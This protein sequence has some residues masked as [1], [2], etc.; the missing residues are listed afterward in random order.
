MSEPVVAG[1]DA[2]R[3]MLADLGPLL[4]SLHDRQ[5]ANPE[6]LKACCAAAYGLDLITTFLGEW[7]HPGGVDLT[8][9]LADALDLRPGQHVLDVA[10]GIGSTALL[11]AQERAVKV[12]G[13][14]LGAAQ[15]AKA[16][17]RAK[18]LGLERVICFE[19]GDAERLPIDDAC[20]DAV[21]CECAFCTFPNK[22]T[23]AAQ[24]ARVLRPGGKA[25]IADVW[26]EPDRLEPEL[27]GVAGHI[28]CLADAKPIPVIH[29]LLASAGLNVVMTERHDEAL[30]TVTE[31]IRAT[32]RALKI[33]GL[34][35]ID[36][37]TLERA[38]Y[39]TGK[40]AEV[41]ARGDAGYVLLVAQRA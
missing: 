7:Y 30:A 13:V 4:D 5:A 9:R 2:L 31:R 3:T 22:Q 15:I 16:Q 21:V 18:T 17:A 27:A 23:A 25:G 40:A 10:S 29:D 19:S 14:E 35:D 24:M 12:T 11:L 38:I 26:L 20:F 1:D 8:R 39:L 32:L 34:P 28:A 6:Q 37:H 36:R 33:I 41:I